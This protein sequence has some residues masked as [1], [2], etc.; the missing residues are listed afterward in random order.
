MAGDIIEIRNL[1]GELIFRLNV[2][3]TKNILQ[4]EVGQ[5]SNGL[6][7]VEKI[8]NGMVN[9]TGKLVISKR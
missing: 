4:M 8:N 6:Y 2:Q 9:K 1:I 7:T 5:I 3:A